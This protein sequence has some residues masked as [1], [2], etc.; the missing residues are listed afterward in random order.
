MDAKAVSSIGAGLVVLVGITTDDTGEDMEYIARRILNT[1]VFEDAAGKPWRASVVDRGLDVLCVSQF[2]L[3]A[4]LKGNKPDFHMVRAGGREGGGWSRT[5]EIEM[6][7]RIRISTLALC[8]AD[9]LTRPTADP[10][11]FA[12]D[13]ERPQP[14][15]LRGLSGAHAQELSRRPHP[16]SVALHF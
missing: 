4:K 12:G 8:V 9:E 10:F 1:R 11:A 15:V 13:E 3:Y 7:Q 14:R 2:T 6:E 5:T 16:R